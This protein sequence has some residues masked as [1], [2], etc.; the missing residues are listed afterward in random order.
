MTK[1]NIIPYHLNGPNL[2]PARIP[3]EPCKHVNSNDP[4]LIAPHP[5]TLRASLAVWR[6][7]PAIWRRER[8]AVGA[9]EGRTWEWAASVS[10]QASNEP[11]ASDHCAATIHRLKESNSLPNS[12][13]LET[14]LRWNM[15]VNIANKMISIRSL[16][17][18]VS[19]NTQDNGHSLDLGSHNY[20]WN[21]HWWTLSRFSTPRHQH[22]LPAGCPWARIP[23]AGRCW[24]CGW[25]WGAPGTGAAD[26][27]PRHRHRSLIKFHT[28]QKWARKVTHTPSLKQCMTAWNSRFFVGLSVNSRF[29][30]ST[31]RIE[32]SMGSTTGCRSAG[33]GVGLLDEEQ[34]RSSYAKP[35]DLET[36]EANRRNMGDFSESQ[37]QSEHIARETQQR[38]HDTMGY[39]KQR[40]GDG[41]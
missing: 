17:L 26:C 15:H 21:R 28:N 31:N 11:S 30:A 6:F 33:G 2:F 13:P 1:K 34:N 36:G 39:G 35:L 18:Q 9:W 8:R 22:H 37:D 23:L 14:P 16:S 24:N 41:I 12:R 38:H 5:K 32:S 29:M 10:V 19:N 40:E 3:N 7:G 27:W 25:G 20:R 4:H